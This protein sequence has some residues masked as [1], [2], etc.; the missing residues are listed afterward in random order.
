MSLQREQPCEYMQLKAGHQRP[1]AREV[2]RIRRSRMV[3]VEN[4]QKF[5][6]LVELAAG[7][8]SYARVLPRPQCV[9]LECALLVRSILLQSASTVPSGHWKIPGVFAVESVYLRLAGV[10]QPRPAALSCQIWQEK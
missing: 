9:S 7:L 5:V 10:D 1:A 6:S 4:T 3:R 2:Y 8:M